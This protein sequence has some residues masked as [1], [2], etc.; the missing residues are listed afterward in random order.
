MPKC[1]W[2]QCP[3]YVIVVVLLFNFF[4]K[5]AYQ[6]SSLIISWGNLAV[7]AQYKRI[8]LCCC[9]FSFYCYLFF[10][11]SNKP[12]AY[13]TVLCFEQVQCWKQWDGGSRGSL[14]KNNNSCFHEKWVCREV[15]LCKDLRALC[16]ARNKWTRL[17][18]ERGGLRWKM[19][20]D[21]ARVPLTQHRVIFTDRCWTRWPQSLMC[22]PFHKYVYN[23]CCLRPKYGSKNSE[24]IFSLTQ[25]IWDQSLWLELKGKG[26]QKKWF[27]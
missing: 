18:L 10:S 11:F 12:A 13:L 17:V 27:S 2:P 22:V 23:T 14:L 15:M 4:C 3:F 6:N 20:M 7:L 9:I 16:N 26:I 19:F 1:H 8:F 25:N 24:I 5:R 21:T